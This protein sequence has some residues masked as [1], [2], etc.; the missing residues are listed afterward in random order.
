MSKDPAFLFYSSDFLSGISDLTMEERGQY[1]TL[2]CLQHQKGHLSKKIIDLCVG[3]ATADVLHKFSIDSDG[4]YFSERL[5]IEI[6]KRRQHSEKQRQRA[7][8]GWKK[9]NATADATALPLENENENKDL[10]ILK[11]EKNEFYKNECLQSDQWKETVSMREKIPLDKF[12]LALTDFN[13]HLV[14]IGETKQNLKD[15]KSHFTNWVR[16]KKQIKAKEMA[17]QNKDRL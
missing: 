2:L 4:N 11:S 14:A 13:G 5:D 9:R 7:I 1:I 3:N 6:E 15:Y 10:L 12:D 8:D 17:N 16:V